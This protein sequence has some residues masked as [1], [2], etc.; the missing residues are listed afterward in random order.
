LTARGDEDITEAQGRVCGDRDIRRCA[1]GRS[2]RCAINRD[3]RAA[4]TRDRSAGGE[5]RILTGDGDVE[6]LTARSRSRGYGRQA[7]NRGRGGH[8]QEWSDA[9]LAGAL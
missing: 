9:D 2:D 7:R 4:E 8:D 6:R 1:R 3:A 5:G